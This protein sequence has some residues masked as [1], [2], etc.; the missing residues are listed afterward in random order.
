MAMTIKDLIDSV[1]KLNVLIVEDG[2]DIREIMSSTLEKI[3][4]TTRTAVDGEDGLKKFNEEL[5]DI[6]ISDIRMPN[7]SGNEMINKIKN[8]NPNIPI[9]VVSGHG[10]LIDKENKADLFLN[11][12]IKFDK[13]LESIYNLTKS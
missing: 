5:P 11:K 6:I 10:R 2:E 1:N 9:I 12:P 4:K 13:L 3:F 7:M 8:I